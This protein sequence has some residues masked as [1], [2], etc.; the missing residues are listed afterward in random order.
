MALD[1]TA[2]NPSL[3]DWPGFIT[4]WFEPQQNRGNT[5]DQFA[6]GIKTFWPCPHL[7]SV[8]S[9]VFFP[10]SLCHSSS[11]CSAWP[12]ASTRSNKKRDMP[13]TPSFK[14]DKLLLTQPHVYPSFFFNSYNM[15]PHTFN[16]VYA[17]FTHHHLDA[18]APPSPNCCPAARSLEVLL[19]KVQLRS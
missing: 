10:L 2:L 9:S 11:V 6:M 13:F 16:T 3:T 17:E 7:S 1:S 5:N 14:T 8:S 19:I 12:S 4:L 15:H 18:H